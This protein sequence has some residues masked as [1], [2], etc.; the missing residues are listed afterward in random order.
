M[1]LTMM[2]CFLVTVMMTTSMLVCHI[3]VV[4]GV[5]YMSILV[6]GSVFPS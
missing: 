4:L 1:R 6:I 3:M 5:V 2:S